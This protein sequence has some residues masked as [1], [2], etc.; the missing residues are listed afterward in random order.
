MLGD[1]RLQAAQLSWQPGMEGG[2]DPMSR[3]TAHNAGWT[4][5]ELECPI[6]REELINMSHRQG[7]VYTRAV[8]TVWT[9]GYKV[10]EQRI[11]VVLF[12]CFLLVL[13]IDLLN[14][15]YFYLLTYM[16]LSDLTTPVA[17]FAFLVCVRKLWLATSSRIW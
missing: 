6:S 2:S 16:V 13:D 7:F 3:F 4:L 17:E 14:K 8:Q 11:K 12:I 15:C 5:G 1:M 10:E 9:R